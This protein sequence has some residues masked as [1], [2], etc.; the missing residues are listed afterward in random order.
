MKNIKVGKFFALVDDEDYEWLSS[1]K[2]HWNI[3]YARNSKLGYMHQLIMG[4]RKNR[5]TDHING[6]GLD[7]RRSNLRLIS[8]KNNIR[9]SKK[10]KSKYSRFLGVTFDPRCG[11]YKAQIMVD[12]NAIYLGSTKNERDAAILYNKAAKRH[13]GKYATLNV[14]E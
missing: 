3:G 14:V 4:R 1:I 7:N 5:V 13:F 11:S 8:H 2:W 10:G 9:K 6:N 12:G